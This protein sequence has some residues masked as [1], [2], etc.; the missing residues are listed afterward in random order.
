MGAGDFGLAK[1]LT[2]DD[3]ASSVSN[4]QHFQKFSYAHDL[5]DI[6]NKISWYLKFRLSELLAICVP[7][8]LLIYLMVPNQIFG[9]WVR[10][11]FLEFLCS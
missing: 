4:F 10:T 9:L 6:Y 11:V 8:F 3:L 5:E 7:N 2:S 1:M